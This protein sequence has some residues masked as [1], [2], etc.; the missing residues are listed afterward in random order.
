MIKVNKNLVGL[1]SL[2]L[3][4]SSVGVAFGAITAPE[5]GNLPSAEPKTIISNIFD[6]IA[7][8]VASVAAL[9]IVIGGIM[10][11]TAGGDDEQTTK[12]RRLIIAAVVGLIIVGAAVGITRWVAGLF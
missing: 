10:W 5:S 12:A 6:Y 4:L 7:W 9:M 8:I 11:M 1:M 3:L 2:A